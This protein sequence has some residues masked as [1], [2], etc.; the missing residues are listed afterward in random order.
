MLYEIPALWVREITTWNDDQTSLLFDFIMFVWDNL[1]H[2][3][4][5]LKGGTNI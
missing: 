2:S 4:L 3:C 1:R 5:R